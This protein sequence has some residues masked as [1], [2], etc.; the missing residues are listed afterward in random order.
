[1]KGKN[2]RTYCDLDQD[3]VL[4]RGDIQSCKKISLLKKHL[5]KERKKEEAAGG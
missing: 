5:L 1:M 4:C 3:W 2:L